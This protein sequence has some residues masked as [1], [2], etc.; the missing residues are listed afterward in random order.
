MNRECGVLLVIAVGI[1]FIAFGV[2]GLCVAEES[3]DKSIIARLL[4]VPIVLFFISLGVD[5]LV[6]RNASYVPRAKR[7]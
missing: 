7:R 2:I 3:D 1:R 5:L 4:L 6:N